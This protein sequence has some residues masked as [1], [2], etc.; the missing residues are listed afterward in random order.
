M[1]LARLNY[2]RWL[3]AVVQYE[4]T[5]SDRLVRISQGILQNRC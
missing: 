3:G 2:Y 4:L 5:S 1:S